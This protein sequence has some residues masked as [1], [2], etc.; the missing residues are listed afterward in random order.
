MAIDV[1]ALKLREIDRAGQFTPIQFGDIAKAGIGTA[2]QF[3]AGQ[4]QNEALQQKRQQA[5]Q[6]QKLLN[7]GANAVLQTIGQLD[8]EDQKLIFG[9]DANTISSLASSQEGLIDV[10]KRVAEVQAA[11]AGEA[12]PTFGEKVSEFGKRGV[13][14][15]KEQL[16]FQQPDKDKPGVSNEI[17][18]MFLNDL[19]K[20]EKERGRSA[21]KSE[22]AS[23]LTDIG[24]RTG[25]PKILESAVAKTILSAAEGA[26]TQENRVFKEKEARIKQIEKFGKSLQSSSEQGNIFNDLAKELDLFGATPVNIVDDKEFNIIRAKFT[27]TPPESLISAFITEKLG[28]SPKDKAQAEL[29]RKV[30]QDPET[31][32]ILKSGSFSNIMTKLAKLVNII[33]K[34]RSGAAVTPNELERMKLEFGIDLLGSPEQFRVGLSNFGDDLFFSMQQI[35]GRTSRSAL[36]AFRRRK[37]T[38]TSSD[39]LRGAPQSLTPEPSIQDSTVQRDTVQTQVQ[40]RQERIDALKR[41]QLQ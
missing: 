24:V 25:I 29:L 13:I 19:Q 26:G 11:R 15:P 18:L 38:F 6:M 21:N 10:W 27:D 7:G 16:G 9:G 4:E 40:T 34:D 36:N 17:N 2:Q 5:A 41:K 30:R 23:L 37:G 33:T 28:A 8:P 3:I 22:T 20:F 12:A 14:T 31:A 35:E 39:L 32:K 1:E